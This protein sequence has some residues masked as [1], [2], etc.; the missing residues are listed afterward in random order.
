MMALSLNKA[1]QSAKYQFPP[2]MS[3]VFPGNKW[4]DPAVAALV[5]V[6]IY[7]NNLRYLEL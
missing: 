3:H 4:T 1:K 2:H 6:K 7:V 5:Q